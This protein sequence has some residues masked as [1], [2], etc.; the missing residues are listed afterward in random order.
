[1]KRYFILLASA[2]IGVTVLTGLG[3]LTGTDQWG[4]AVADTLSFYPVDLL[5]S[6][7]SF[8]GNMEITGVIALVLAVRWRRR[9]GLRGFLAPMLLFAGV[10]VE[11]VLKHALIHP[12]PPPL[13]LQTRWQSPFFSLSLTHAL[14]YWANILPYSFPSGHLL[15]TTFLVSLIMGQPGQRYRLAGATLIATMAFTRV[16]LNDHWLSDVIGGCLLGFALAALAAAIRPAQSG[17]VGSRARS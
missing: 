10:A 8:L 7:F 11:V 2:F 17:E 12:P 1:M 15:R 4:R 3:V 6:V 13:I 9:Y 16:Y 14:P 5:G